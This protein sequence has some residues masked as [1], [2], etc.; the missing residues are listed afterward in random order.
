MGVQMSMLSA[1]KMLAGFDV[2]FR[3]ACGMRDCKRKD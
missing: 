1:I 3:R 2:V